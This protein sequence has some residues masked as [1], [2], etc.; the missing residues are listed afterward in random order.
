V[1]SNGYHIQWADKEQPP[2][3]CEYANKAGC[4]GVNHVFTTEAIAK[5]I[6]QGALQLCK[7]EQLHC[8]LAMDVHVNSEGKQLLIVDARPVNKYELTRKFKCETLTKEGRDIF[9]GCAYGGSI[10]ISHAYHH[11]EMAEESRCYL[12]V[13]WEGEYYMWHVLPF[14]LSSAP[15]IWVK[16]SAEPVAE[17]RRWGVRVM[18]YMDD[19]PHGA[20]TTRSVDNAKRMIDFL[21]R[22]WFVIELARKCVGYDAP[23]EVFAALGFIIDLKGQRFVMKPGR[24]ARISAFARELLALKGEELSAKRVAA[25]AGT[26]VS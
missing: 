3:P 21:L 8:I 14:G 18:H 16:V 1:I 10:D 15:Y 6:S 23:L 7:R 20:V 2:P 19:L 9:E 11:I 24:L 13:E 22:C 5:L 4:F 17:F 25:F 26:V 12:G